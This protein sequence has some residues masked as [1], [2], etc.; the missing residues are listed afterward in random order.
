[1]QCILTMNIIWHYKKTGKQAMK[2]ME[3]P[4]MHI[5]EW[6]EDKFKCLQY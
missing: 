5:T 1:M 6:K 4:Y 3:E 2:H